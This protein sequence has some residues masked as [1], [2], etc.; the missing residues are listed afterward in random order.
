MSRIWGKPVF[1]VGTVVLIGALSGALSGCAGEARTSAGTAPTASA[2]VT[3]TATDATVVTPTPTP[4]DT[5]V[6]VTGVELSAETMD[7]TSSDGSSVSLTY[8]D[9]I[10]S[11]VAT[12]SAA[13]GSA[14]VVDDVTPTVEPGPQTTYTWP[15]VLIVD[16][17]WPATMPLDSNF[18]VNITAPEINGV[19]L[20][21]TGDIQVGDSA[22]PLEAQYPNSASGSSWEELTVYFATVEVPRS[23]TNQHDG[24]SISVLVNTDN[25]AGVITSISA[26]ASN[27]GV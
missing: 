10:D 4:S 23:D 22:F 3:P 7:L 8:F 9:P 21:T 13:F 11:V 17:D 2:S 6:R 16:A 26:P 20:G 25:P 5:A 15:G 1:F 14:P 27:Y 18:Y 19:S 24:S 12:L